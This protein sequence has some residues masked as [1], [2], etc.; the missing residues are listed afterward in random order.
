MRCDE[1]PFPVVDHSLLALLA[2]V[3]DAF[4]SMCDGPGAKDRFEQSDHSGSC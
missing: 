3:A 4:Q 1:L 2:G